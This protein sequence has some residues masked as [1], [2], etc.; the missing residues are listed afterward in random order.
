MSHIFISYSRKDLA[1]AQKIVDALAANNLDTWIDWKSIPKGEDWEQEIYRGIEEADA[2][3]FLISPDSV[4]SEMCNKEIVHAYKNGKRILPIVLRDTNKK[5]FL[6]EVAKNEISKRNW[7]FCRDGQDDF[8]KVIEETHKTIHTDYE[9]LKYHTELQVKA[10][11]WE[12]KKDNSRLLRGKELREAEQQLAEVGMQEDPQPTTMQR[13]YILAS[14][15]NEVRQRR[16]ISAGLGIG[17]AIVAVLAVFAWVQRNTAVTEANS[18]ATAESNAITEANAKATAL[19][20]EESARATAQ[21]EKERAEEQT[22]IARAN[23]LIT[24]S[25]DIR[26]E[27]IITS[28]LLAVEAYY[29][30]PDQRSRQLLF[31]NLISNSQFQR[32]FYNCSEPMA[33]SP[34]GELFASV[35]ESNSI[36]IRDAKTGEPTKTI[37]GEHLERIEKITFNPDSKSI[38]SISSDNTIALWEVSTGL[39]VFEKNVAGDFVLF[40]DITFNSNGRILTLVSFDI[41]TNVVQLDSASGMVLNQTRFD[42]GYS[43]GGFAISP[44]GETLAIGSWDNTI[45]LW[46]VQSRQAIGSPLIGHSSMPF[47]LVFSTDSQYL[48]S[49]DINGFLIL[50]DVVSGN[51]KDLPVVVGANYSDDFAFSPDSKYIAYAN[52]A[53]E[54]ALWD[55]SESKQLGVALKGHSSSVEKIVYSFDGR[56]ISSY[57]SHNKMILWDTLTFQDVSQ[58]PENANPVSDLLVGSDCKVYAAYANS[59]ILWNM[60]GY[61]PVQQQLGSSKISNLAFSP[62][63]E[64]LASVDFDDHI[65]LWNVK[66][67]VPIWTVHS[68][69]HKMIYSIAFNPGGDYLASSSLLDGSIMLWKINET[70][71]KGELLSQTSGGVMK[72]VFIT[73]NI[74]ASANLDG[75]LVLWNL[76]GGD[77]LTTLRPCKDR[78]SSDEGGVFFIAY[79]SFDRTIAVTCGDGNLYLIR[80]WYPGDKAVFS[81]YENWGGNILYSPDGEI[82]AIARKTQIFLFN[83]FGYSSYERKSLDGIS[84]FVRSITFTRDGKWIASGG[85]DKMVTLWDTSTGQPFVQLASNGV[86]SIYSVALQP[87]GEL[88]ASGGDYDSI[89]L[90]D[91]NV[92]SWIDKTCKRVGRNLTREE[93]AMYLVG[94]EYRKTCNAWPGEQGVM[95]NDWPGELEVIPTLEGPPLSDPRSGF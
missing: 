29:H 80:E 8:N 41:E 91:I 63:G 10:L 42:L 76:K 62:N 16:Q 2:F 19:V 9:W 49:K 17:L 85:D 52:T 67:G 65:E 25:I 21:A 82:L 20:N 70:E 22:Q 7:I 86:G 74:L 93:W 55:I 73:D 36:V 38:V 72:I 53:N 89:F 33:I 26:E 34:N 88:V 95:P 69:Q 27:N 24:K 23:Y 30:L 43:A 6:D 32:N 39:A 46:D 71:P 54:I 87:S 37:Q 13:E 28:S 11:K 68:N 90:W 57:D 92:E 4:V 45:Q 18:R 59:L 64:F 61:L 14:Q 77:I 40:T 79:N 51:R 56:Y 50:W 3:L 44:N 60:R 12:H 5:D 58:I 47:K 1:F 83:D 66:T 31:E 35:C 84:A 48:L 78:K 15:R 75:T 94:E 81:R